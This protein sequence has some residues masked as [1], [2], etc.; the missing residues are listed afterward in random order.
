MRLAPVLSLLALALFPGAQAAALPELVRTL[1]NKVTVVVREVHSRP[2]V[3]IQAWV[4]AGT[5]DEATKDR[6]LAITTAQCIMEA[7]TR[8]DPG[9]MQREIY[10]L[11]GTYEGNAGYDYSY[12]DL[13]LPAHSFGVGLDLLAEGLTQA[14]ID[15]PIV[16]LALGRAKG[17][18]RTVLGD[19][20]NAAVNTVRA[21]LYE[22]T[23]LAA[24]LAIP[25]E[26]F[27]PITP[28]L[29]Q[30]FYRDYYIAENLTLVVTGDVDPEE[31]VQ[32]VSTAFQGMQRG[33][34]P[35]R[36][37]ISAR[38]LRGPIAVLE[39]T[40]N[41]TRGA[42]V[43][44]GFR[45]PAWGSAD[46]L[47]LDALMAILIDTPTSRA[48]A[49]LIT[50]NAEFIHASVIRDY[51]TDGGTIALS[52][53]ADQDSLEDA[54]GALITLIEQARST[55]ITA[56]EF[57]LAVRSLLQRDLFARADQSGVGRALALA[58]LRGAPG[59]DDVYVQRVSALRPEDLIA[60]AR[61]YL[62]MDR[63][64]VVEMGPE[65]SVGKIKAGDL[66][67][68]IR[69]KRAVYGAAYRSG[70]QVTASAD[71]ERQA[72]VDAPLKQIAGAKPQSAGRGRVTRS[73]IA[74]GARVLTSED[75]SAP[76]VTVA[77]Y[78][79][80]GVRYEND[81]NNG[82]TSL[83]RETLLNS[84]DP[85]G[86]GLTYRQSLSQMGRLVSYQDKD[87]W[88]CS[89]TI[90]SDSWR[91]A[92]AMMGRLFAHP[93][94]DH[95][96]VDATRILVL[97]A[98]DRW[99]HDDEAQRERLIFPTKYVVSGYRLPS[100]GSHRTL[101]SIPLDDVVGWYQKFVVQPNMV[102]CVF[103][104][105]SASSVQPEV[106]REFHDVSTRAFQPGTVAK[107][108]DFDGFREK[109]ELGAGPNS[110]VTIAFNGPPA[111]S[112]DI[113][114]LYVV[115][116]LLGGP[117]GWL[118][119]Y[120][121]KTGGAKGTNAILSQAMD[122]S[123]LL[124][125]LTVGGPLQEED[126]VKLAF[127]QIKKAALLP[128]HGDLAPDLVNAKTLASGGFLMGLG[129]DPTRALQFGRAELFGLGID[130]PIVLPAKIDGVTS[131][132]LL[133]V[134][135]KYLQRDQWNRAAYSVCETRPGGW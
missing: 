52:F 53:A 123:P 35:S 51:E 11:A 3:S 2:I 50:G 118:E 121:T 88:G 119:E 63:A 32:K 27:S 69:D 1:P 37:R 86:K 8:R 64:V 128:L 6:G 114:V 28:T 68:R 112:P 34:V 106:E 74:G 111:R 130:Y 67:R 33:K 134:G 19:A 77:V 43:V 23:P 85:Q 44:A 98:L 105:V 47:A 131:D 12:F 31:V 57:R 92:L 79:L 76:L 96:N 49:K 9:A 65:A 113:P 115:A 135:L 89:L 10:S 21:R 61:K 95:V 133:R 94:L 90:P 14:R 82:I 25:E 5:R 55:P 122:E 97:D 129:S 71:A 110:T 109:W 104:D 75:H 54:E 13:T 101:V 103:G 22:G 116:A 24:P 41:E 102:V 120:V 42:A 117:K 58:V 108:G 38:A 91:D 84:N 60:V 66:D 73:V 15:K 45:A 20:D 18:A 99:L 4:R 17:L 7:T 132:D 124:A 16:D 39:K 62:D 126:M 100:L 26:E 80:G 40:P 83:V 30:R 46:A 125:T 81:N 36:S 72:R 29:I 78:F 56:E 107:E 93:D 59:S 70:P 48:S 127:R 87:M